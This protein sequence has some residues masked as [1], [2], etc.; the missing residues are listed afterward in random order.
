LPP[1]GF[2]QV[3]ILQ[4][5]GMYPYRCEACGARFFRRVR[6]GDV[7]K[8]PPRSHAI[9]RAAQPR[10]GDRSADVAQNVPRV[11]APPE[12]G[13]DDD[14][15]HADFVD[16]IDHISRSEQRKGL[17]APKKDGGDD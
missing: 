4:R 15:S 13:F 12:A 11:I 14:L 1:E 2:W 5:I 6:V 10:P 17:G 3:Q 9:K 8:T 16:L 7:A